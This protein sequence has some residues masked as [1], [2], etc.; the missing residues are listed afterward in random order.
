MSHPGSEPSPSEAVT[1]RKG[2]SPQL[3]HD[4]LCAL[5]RLV[6][7]HMSLHIDQPGYRINEWLKPQIAAA[8]ERERGPKTYTPAELGIVFKISPETHAKIDQIEREAAETMRAIQVDK[9]VFR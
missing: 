6:C 7:E 8:A 9:T 5:G 4:D 2:V 1:S 3:S